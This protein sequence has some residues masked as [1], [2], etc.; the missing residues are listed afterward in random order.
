M[1]TLCVCVNQVVPEV[2]F[3]LLVG[4]TVLKVVWRSVSIM[5]GELYVTRCGMMQ[6]VRWSV[7]N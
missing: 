1:L 5:S 4:Q 7:G 6:M 2:K 3:D